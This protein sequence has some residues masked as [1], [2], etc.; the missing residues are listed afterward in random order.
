MEKCDRK[1]N[2]NNGI[3]SHLLSIQGSVAELGYQPK[4]RKPVSYLI[5]YFPHV[6]KKLSLNKTAQHL[7]SDL[8]YGENG[9][10]TTLK[11]HLRLERFCIKICYEP[12]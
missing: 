1:Y 10:R 6:Q 8:S 5:D 12:R 9:T 3:S 4:I 7:L 11:H 2:S